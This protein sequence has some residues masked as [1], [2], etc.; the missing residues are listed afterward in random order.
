M[1]QRLRELVLSEDVVKVEDT[2]YGRKFSIEGPLEC[3]SGEKVEIVTVWV[4]L[5]GENIPRFVTVY[6][7]G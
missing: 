4:M 6:P 3:P 1:E 5:N 2:R 7:G